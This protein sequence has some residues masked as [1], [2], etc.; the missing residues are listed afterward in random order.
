MKR[1]LAI[2]LT[3]LAA[4]LVLLLIGSLYGAIW[5][6]EPLSSRLG[7]TCLATLLPAFAAVWG[8]GMAW[9]EVKS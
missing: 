4:L 5:T 6:D 1:N 8:A 7:Q 3:V 9:C 2:A